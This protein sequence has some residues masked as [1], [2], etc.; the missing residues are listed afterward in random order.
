MPMRAFVFLASVVAIVS[1]SAAYAVAP[2]VS[3][4][5]AAQRGGG[6]RL[7]DVYYDLADPDS[8]LLYVSLK[9]S[10]DGGA[11]WLI[12]PRTVSGAVGT[13]VTPGGGKHI[14][15]DAGADV[16][17]VYGTQYKAM[18]TVSDSNSAYPGEMVFIPAGEFLM[19]S[20]ATT[21]TNEKPQHSVNLSGYWIGRTEVTRGEY[22]QFMDAGGYRTAVY[23][24]SAGWNWKVSNNRTQPG[25]WD[26]VQDWGTGAFTQ[27]DEHPVVGVSHYEAE[28][29]CR[30]AGCRLPTEAEWE[31]AARWDGHPREYPWGDAWHAAYCN[32]YDD[33]NVL[34]GGYHK[35][36]TAPVGSYPAGVSP[37][38][39][40]DMA[41][42]VWE[43]CAD[44]YGASYYSQTPGGGWVDPQG[45]ASGSSRVL[46]GG[47]WSNDA[48]GYRAA[49][50]DNDNPGY[51]SYLNGFRVAR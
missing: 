18:L 40:H 33:D 23:W 32:N 30:W 39:L 19:G 51:T 12:I 44:W 50:R 27:T 8:S 11:S 47:S 2:N 28:A 13:N 10:N 29:F 31:K 21:Y 26:A 34:G 24:S 48:Y 36:Q 49:Y 1:A 20:V 41:G 46:R 9:I 6:S 45:P 14:V 37:Y 17:G 22:R 25:N 16:P 42:N 15:W 5:S 4:I 38:G 7:V 3:N 35:Y 43:W